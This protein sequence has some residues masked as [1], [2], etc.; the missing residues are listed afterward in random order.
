MT[1]GPTYAPCMLDGLELD[2]AQGSSFWHW[3]CF[4]FGFCQHSGIWGPKDW[5]DIRILHS[6]LR[7]E[8]NWNSRNHGL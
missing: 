7:P 4:L 6:G 8:E 5:V 1:L 2:I 3:S